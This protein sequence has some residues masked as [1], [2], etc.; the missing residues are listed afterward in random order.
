[1]FATA[2]LPD[3]ST[4]GAMYVAFLDV[5]I[6][7]WNGSD[8]ENVDRRHWTRGDRVYALAL[9]PANHTLWIG[10]DIGLSRLDSLS[11]VTYDSHDG[12][13]NG[14][15]RAIMADPAGGYWF[16]GQKGLSFYEQESTPPWLQLKS[17]TSPGQLR[18]WPTAGRSMQGRRCRP[19]SQPATPSPPRTS[20]RCSIVSTGTAW[21][22]NGTW[23]A[24][25]R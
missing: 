17:V 14:A 3:P 12:M 13:E 20:W 6:Y 23:P 8:W 1:M 21:P 10:S 25:R 2:L 9:E 16:G 7:R 22:T 18:P 15:V 11:L 24:P 4:A 19:S 5:G